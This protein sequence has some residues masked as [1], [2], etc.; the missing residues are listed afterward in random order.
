LGNGEK[1]LREKCQGGVI[2]IAN[3]QRQA[4]ELIIFRKVALWL[5]Q[6]FDEQFKVADRDFKRHAKSKKTRF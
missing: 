1:G 4:K 5:R 6:L 3:R 2:S